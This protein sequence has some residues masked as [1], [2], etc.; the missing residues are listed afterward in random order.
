VN[1]HF[2]CSKNKLPYNF[3]NENA[4]KYSNRRFWD[5]SQCEL[6]QTPNCNPTDTVNTSSGPCNSKW[7]KG[8]NP[9]P[10]TYYDKS[11]KYTYDYKF[12][13]RNLNCSSKCDNPYNECKQTVQGDCGDCGNSSCCHDPIVKYVPA[14]IGTNC[15]NI[16]DF[17]F[18]PGSSKE[19]YIA[20][21]FDEQFA[22]NNRYQ[23][24]TVPLY[25]CSDNNIIDNMREEEWTES[26]QKALVS[27]GI[28]NATIAKKFITNNSK[29]Y[30]IPMN[31][32]GGTSYYYFG[33]SNASVKTGLNRKDMA[34]GI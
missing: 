29:C 16:V 19:K 8:C 24:A 18:K 25:N 12:N 26:D 22:F 33:T 15:D 34:K 13:S 23:C 5:R 27:R 7:T 11:S 32:V 14:D 1:R 10:D 6:V 9:Y 3:T 2:D 17:K 20:H 31:V 4:T 30:Q 21:R 28:K